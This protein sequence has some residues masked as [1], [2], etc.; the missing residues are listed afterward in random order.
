MKK[1]MLTMIFIS[2][3]NAL[4]FGLKI[5]EM[6]TSE[7]NAYFNH[8]YGESRQFNC[9]LRSSFLPNTKKGKI[10]K[11]M[12]NDENAYK[13]LRSL[14]CEINKEDYFIWLI[15]QNNILKQIKY[16]IKKDYKIF[17]SEI[18]KKY[19]LIKES[20]IRLD[21]YYISNYD[22]FDINE[23]TTCEGKY[24]RN[25]SIY[26]YS[27]DIDLILVDATFNTITKTTIIIRDKS[28]EKLYIKQSNN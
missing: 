9:N 28:L 25:F 8:T 16:E 12:F 7:V 17:K 22:E 26:E 21:D 11:D 4:D 23:N 13:N 14:A 10:I 5:N 3:L 19:K 1:L 6:T 18:N 27:K 15:F 24:C 2:A 20:S